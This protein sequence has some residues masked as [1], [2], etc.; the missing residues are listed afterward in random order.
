[1]KKRKA[2]GRRKVA[3]K[4][5]PQHFSGLKL[6]ND[7]AAVFLFIAIL[8]IVIFLLDAFADQWFQFG[9]K[10]SAAKA[11]SKESVEKAVL[12]KFVINSKEQDGLGFIVK[13][14]VDPELLE[15]FATKEYS[16]VK[17]ELGLLAIKEELKKVYRFGL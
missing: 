5:A 15:H 10:K 12:S 4:P 9:E 17:K 14:T 8:V 6:I 3:A 1:M 11:L 16:Q 2:A 13:D 7:K